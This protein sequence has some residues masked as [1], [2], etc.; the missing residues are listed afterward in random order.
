MLFEVLS[1]PLRKGAMSTQ[2]QAAKEAA[3]GS[4]ASVLL[5]IRHFRQ[6]EVP[7]LLTDTPLTQLGIKDSLI[8]TTWRSL[9]FLGLITEEG[10]TTDK[11]RALRFA[12]DD[13]YGQVLGDIITEAYSDVVA[14]APP[15]SANRSQMLNAFRPYRPASQQG[16]MITLFLA[17]CEEAGMPVSQPA[18]RSSQRKSPTG[19]PAPTKV[20][21]STGAGQVPVSSGGLPHDSAAS[22]PSYT[23]SDPLIA[24]LVAKLPIAGTIWPEPEREEFI[25]AFK[26][27]APMVWKDA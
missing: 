23:H 14:I 4:P 17:L 8:R 9:V 15:E 19:R 12:T 18:K 22:K 3:Y 5:V 27:I 11:F 26:A 25:A 20:S 2:S 21:R 6:R 16:R 10:I 7:E 13:Q 1:P 24:A